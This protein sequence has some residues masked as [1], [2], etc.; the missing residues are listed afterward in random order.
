MEDCQASITV[1]QAGASGGFSGHWIFLA[2]EKK[3]Q[4]L[5]STDGKPG[6][7]PNSKF[8]MTP[9]AYMTDSVYA[10]I[11]PQLADGIQ[12]MPHIC[13]H[14][15]WWVVVC[16]DGF[17][18]LVNVH[19][20]QEA[21]FQRK[22]MILK[23]EGDTSHVNEAY[24]QSVAKNDK[25]GMRA[26]LDLICP[27]I[28]VRL[29]QCYLITIAIEALKKIKPA[30]WVE[31]FKKVNLH[32]QLRVTQR[33]S[34]LFDAMPAVSKN[35]S[36]QDRHAVMSVIDSFYK[37]KTL[38]GRPIWTT[39]NVLRLVEYVPLGDVEK[40]RCCYLAAK[41]EPSV[42]VFDDNSCRS[43]AGTASFSHA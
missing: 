40:L 31:S 4:A 25:A 10:E 13:E 9:L 33:T 28:G 43:H 36:V 27:H 3:C 1:L 21:F 6:V 39:K 32:P 42:F 24:D 30:A 14:P 5:R 37:D 16:L 38:D 34:S 29:D 8:Y 17:G 7:P 23:E 2:A 12:K 41:Q 20:A 22:I 35:L 19:M 18:S 15:E 26:N 11:A